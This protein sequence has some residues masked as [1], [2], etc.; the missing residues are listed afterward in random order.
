M[1]IQTSLSLSLSSF[2]MYMHIE[3]VLAFPELRFLRTHF[4]KDG[5]N[6]YVSYSR[7]FGSV[8]DNR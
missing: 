4:G 1:Y 2:Y 7:C 6:S 8:P 5:Y 3:H